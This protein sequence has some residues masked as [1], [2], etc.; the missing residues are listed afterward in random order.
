MHPRPIIPHL[1]GVSGL[2]GQGGAEGKGDG[3]AD[4][5]AQRVIQNMAHLLA[6]RITVGDGLAAGVGVGVVYL[7]V[8]EGGKKTG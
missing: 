1:I 2:R 4:D 8:G 7:V 3:V 5:I 6:G